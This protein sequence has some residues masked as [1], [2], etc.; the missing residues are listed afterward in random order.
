MKKQILIGAV[1]YGIGFGLLGY[2]I[3][4]NWDDIAQR[5]QQPIQVWP[6]VLATSLCA[7]S[8]LITFIRWYVLVRA[9][10]LDITLTNALRLGLVGFFF[11]TYL[12]GSVGGDIVK[13]FAIAREQRRRTVAV[14]TVIIDRLIGLWAL[15]WLVAILGSI[16]WLADDPGLHDQPRLQWVLL[17][18]LAVVAV[19]TLAYLSLFLLPRH[20]AHRL[21]G[22]LQTRV[23]GSAA[24]FWRAIWMYRD[25]WR[26]VLLAMG[27]SLVGHV[28]FVLTFYF[29]ALVYLNAS[30][31]PTLTQ[32]FLIVPI[33]MTI[34]AAVPIP[35]GVGI[36]EWGF[37]KL[38]Y[39]IG[40]PEANGV[41]AS[42]TQ[43]MIYWVL[44]I[45]GYLVYLRMPTT[46]QATAKGTNQDQQPERTDAE[47]EPP[48]QVAIPEA[49]LSDA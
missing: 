39:I 4:R 43:R 7:V 37:G 29:S 24:E 8:I 41:F 22:W 2:V 12:P 38:Y 1:K 31:I 19:S 14:A 36:G 49:R 6:L 47:P 21:A 18:V 23:G 45:V 15:F 10:Q 25:Q 3:W 20:Q 48:A 26:S 32:H 5:L 17:A 42:F 27:M 35:G 9:Q 11:S 33:G 40:M 46:M 13:A 30:Q 28:G 16:F 34:Q 44:A